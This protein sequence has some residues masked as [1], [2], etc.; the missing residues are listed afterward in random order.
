MSHVAASAAKRHRVRAEQLDVLPH[1][2]EY[3]FEPNQ[4]IEKGVE[5]AS[6]GGAEPAG[7]PR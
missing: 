5:C 1:F 3:S 6:W 2:F 4:S 7:E